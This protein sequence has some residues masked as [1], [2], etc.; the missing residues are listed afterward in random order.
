MKLDKI[1]YMED[2]Y[3]LSKLQQHR[4]SQFQ[5]IWEAAGWKCLD[6]VLLAEEL[7]P[8]QYGYSQEP[9]RVATITA[10][11][12]LV[13]I[14]MYAYI[15]GHRRFKLKEIDKALECSTTPLFQPR[16]SPGPQI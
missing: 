2:C 14:N 9:A 15:Q 4:W 16:C 3:A 13:C 11:Q 8:S 12:M 6:L 5:Q 7:R 10:S 1:C